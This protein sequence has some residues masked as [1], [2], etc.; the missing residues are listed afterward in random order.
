M[1]FL[2]SILAELSLRESDWAQDQNQGLQDSQPTKSPL[3]FS[4]LGWAPFFAEHFLIQSPICRGQLIIGTG[5]ANTQGSERERD[6]PKAT[7]PVRGGLGL[8][9]WR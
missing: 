5:H 8:G 1:G 7:Q 4:D 2:A 9:S 3:T 6:L